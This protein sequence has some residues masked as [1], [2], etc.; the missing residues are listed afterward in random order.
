MRRADRQ[1]LR[2]GRGRR[3]CAGT[4]TRVQ[5]HAPPRPSSPVLRGSP[6]HFALLLLRLFRA[7]GTPANGR[8]TTAA[9]SRRP[10]TVSPAP[11]HTH[12]HTYAAG[13]FV[14]LFV[15]SLDLTLACFE[16][17]RSRLSPYTEKSRMDVRV[18]VP[19]CP[20]P[21]VPLCRCP[22]LLLPLPVRVRVRA[23]AADRGDDG[24]ESS[25]SSAALGIHGECAEGAGEARTRAVARE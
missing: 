23:R 16:F 15:L 14:S 13:V 7:P 19:L 11:L 17:S 25:H 20:L 5:A 2:A 18:C 22:A 4:P 6:R 3:L 12:T 21:V 1:A 9:R 8:G 24:V 10:S